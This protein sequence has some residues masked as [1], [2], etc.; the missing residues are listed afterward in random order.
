MYVRLHEVF[1]SF[2]D[3]WFCRP[4]SSGPSSKVDVPNTTQ[5]SYGHLHLI[6]MW[7]VMD[8]RTNTKETCAGNRLG[9]TSKYANK[10]RL[11]NKMIWWNLFEWATQWAWE[12][13]IW[14][15]I[16]YS[17]ELWKLCSK[18][19]R[20]WCEFANYLALIACLLAYE[21]WVDRKKVS[22]YHTSTL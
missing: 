2:L 6:G 20:A 21:K 3:F 9:Y 22:E 12:S 13:P 10:I 17:Y 16:R 18:G 5:Q 11:N 1:P 15:L 19:L 8:L 14:Q 7:L 4:S